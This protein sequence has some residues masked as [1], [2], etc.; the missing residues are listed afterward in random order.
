MV[1]K[2]KPVTPKARR[3]PEEPLTR[4]LQP[5]AGAAAPVP[6]RAAP[7]P[8][9]RTSPRKAPETRTDGLVELV[10]LREDGLQGAGGT[11]VA[12]GQRGWFS[13]DEAYAYLTARN[14]RLPTAED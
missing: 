4:P 14:A 11:F 5:P 9:P 3:A 7:A 6:D 12:A 8:P 10:V 13:S 2:K 1:A